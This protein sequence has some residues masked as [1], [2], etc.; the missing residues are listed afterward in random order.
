MDLNKGPMVSAAGD[1]SSRW[2]EPAQPTRAR[3]VAWV[4]GPWRAGISAGR[5][6]LGT[7]DGRN[8]V[9]SAVATPA[10]GVT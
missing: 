4:A 7:A 5:L 1:H 9:T 6:A 8:H 2:L 10:I 3:A